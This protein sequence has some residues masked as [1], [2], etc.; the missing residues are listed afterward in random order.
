MTR[1]RLFCLFLAVLMLFTLAPVATA[2]SGVYF[3]MLNSNAPDSLSS[4]TMPFVRN[5]NIYVPQSVLE[6]LG[7][8]VSRPA[9]ELHLFSGTTYIVFDLVNGGNVTSDGGSLSVSPLARFGTTFFPVGSTGSATGALSS[10]FG[11]NFHIVQTDPAPTVRLYNTSLGTL[12]H[13]AVLNNGELLFGFEARYNTFTGNH[14]GETGGST[15]GET[16]AP[17]TTTPNTPSTPGTPDDD[18]DEPDRPTGPV[19]LSFVGLTAETDTLLD[20]LRQ[21]NVPAGFFLTAEDASL[22]PD[23]VRRLQGEGH[24]VGIYLSA[25]AEE[26]YTAASE[27]LF[28]AARVRTV[29]VTTGTGTVAQDAYDLGLVVFDSAVRQ[30]PTGDALERLTGNLLLHAGNGNTQA[31]AALPGAI[32]SNALRVVSFV[33]SLF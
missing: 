27:A 30:V 17:P 13:S 31:L 7:I 25:D 18:A 21:S 10:L 6:R 14:T 24:Q 26:E 5:G 19:S 2:S 22:H 11:I 20:A 16:P 1:R 8:S 12:S 15:V 28:E 32:R 29:L 4:G 23:L 9:G 33:S 3:T